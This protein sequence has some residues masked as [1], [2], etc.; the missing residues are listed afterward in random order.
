[1]LSLLTTTLALCLSLHLSTGCVTVR[2]RPPFQTPAP[3][4]PFQ[5]QTAPPP[6]TANCKCGV[7]KIG[8]QRIVGGQEAQPHEYPWHVGVDVRNGREPFCGGSLISSRSVL[9]AAHCLRPINSSPNRWSVWLG[10]HFKNGG[11][12]TRYLI[13]KVDY[14]PGYNKGV[15]TDNDFAIMTLASPV[16]FT[17]TISPVCL[18][19]VDNKYEGRTAT[20]TGWGE[21]FEAEGG[22]RPD[23]LMEVDV[24]TMSNARCTTP[25]AVWPRWQ[26]TRN[27]ICAAAPN[28]DS[29]TNDSGGPLV[30]LQDGSF[31]LIGVVS[32]GAGCA[33]ARAP[34][35]YARVTAQLNWI[36]SKM[37]G[38]TCQKA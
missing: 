38:S 31:D 17:N 1:M 15:S 19:S 13:S 29:C 10:R 27:M 37:S 4:P 26:I 36:K 5:T 25:N 2:P 11:G 30:M 9:T 12:G 14:H 33:Q 24:K 35:V 18:P 28:K 16:T 21:L 23:V 6:T 20:T 8:R 22:Q 32:F 34:G 3:P 7:Q